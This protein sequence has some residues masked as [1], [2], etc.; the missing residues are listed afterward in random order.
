MNLDTEQGTL[1]TDEVKHDDPAGAV[2]NPPV[3]QG[4]PVDENGAPVVKQV[5]FVVPSGIPDHIVQTAVRL[6]LETIQQAFQGVSSYFYPAIKTHENGQQ[7]PV[8]ARVV[9]PLSNPLDSTRIKTLMELIAKANID[10]AR[11][12]QRDAVSGATAR[13][14]AE[15]IKDNVTRNETAKADGAVGGI[16]IP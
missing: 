12:Q 13:L 9:C 15:K 10:A 7:E 2:E 16:I 6:G 4:I 1:V 3:V 5:T 11:A 14:E 8:V